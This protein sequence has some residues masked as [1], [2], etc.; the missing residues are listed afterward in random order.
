MD[1]SVK[2]R[3]LQKVFINIHTCNSCL[4][5]LLLI[6]EVVVSL[7]LPSLLVLDC[8]LYGSN[9][10]PSVEVVV[11]VVA[12]IL[13][14][15]SIV[16]LLLVVVIGG[17]IE[18]VPAKFCVPIGCRPLALSANIWKCAVLGGPKLAAT[19]RRAASDELL[20]AVL[21][22]VV[23]APIVVLEVPFKLLIP[24][25]DDEFVIVVKGAVTW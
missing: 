10:F 23:V 6:N 5:I 18:F 21:V 22:V 14:P 7:L 3:N 25:D 19:A 12:V 13:L 9:W 8:I 11:V 20:P 1:S 17:I 4:G 24:F 15:L 16:L 2:I